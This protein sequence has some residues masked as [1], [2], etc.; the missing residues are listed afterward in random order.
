MI[1]L[2]ASGPGLVMKWKGP[3]TFAVEAEILGKRF[4]ATQ[5]SKPREI[6]CRMAQALLARSPDAKP[7]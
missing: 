1:V 6:K 2:V 5:S 4:C 3:S 7:L